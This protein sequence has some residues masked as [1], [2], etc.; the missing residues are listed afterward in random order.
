[1]GNEELISEYVDRNGV[2]GDTKF[3]LEHLNE[4][5]A[6]YNK[7]GSVKI[8]LNGAD[9]LTKVNEATK[10][11]TAANLQYEQSVQRV[12]ER[13]AQLNGHSREFTNVLLQETKAT[14]ELSASRLN[15]AKA[16]ESLAKA[17]SIEEKSTKESIKSKEAE[18]KVVEQAT[19]D[20]LQ[21]SKAYTEAALKAKNY[22][23]QLG[24]NHPLAVAAVKDANDL[25]TVLKNIDSSVG[26]NQRSVGDYG[27][28]ITKSFSKA[29]SAVKTLANIL[30]GLGISGVFLLAG[31]LISDF[32]NGLFRASD[33]V[34]ELKKQQEDF[35]RS[36][37]D[38]SRSSIATSL[39]L[40]N[41][42]AIAK[43]SKLP[44]EQ[45]NTALV[46]ANNIL[47]DHSEKLTL[48]NINTIATTE[49]IK[50]FTDALI[51]QAIATKYADRAAELT[52]KRTKLSK[53]LKE[54]I[55]QEAKA[56]ERS[57]NA[58]GST[59]EFIDA[60]TA[61]SKAFSD[62]REAK[63]SEI[64]E[65]DKELSEVQLDLLENQ[66]KATDILTVP[67]AKK[68]QLYCCGKAVRSK[69]QGSIRNC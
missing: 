6:A 7:L 18:K 17:K 45:R 1:M 27:N 11:A 30:P 10:Q 42:V 68:K 8:G 46:E 26:Q 44:L 2:A 21:L 43:D 9:S 64:R 5:Y 14:K 33:G 13:I 23:L 3:I 60:L 20:Y 34:K 62:L 52:I 50:R 55:D 59:P 38:V 53:E 63:V 4:V 15:D 47:G 22:V 24:A 48:V 49:S 19:N 31:N 36:L 25:G 65:V 58:D 67:D 61:E 66:K 57:K 54:A 35:V 32:V 56:K 69:A 28:A 37:D 39:Q 29:F 12:T 16:A 40:Q 41:F 51:G